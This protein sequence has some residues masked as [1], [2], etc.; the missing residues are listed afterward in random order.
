MATDILVAE[1]SPDTIERM[2]RT[3]MC[4]IRQREQEKVQ[5]RSISNAFKLYLLIGITARPR[6]LADPSG[7][8]S[9]H[10]K[11]GSPNSGQHY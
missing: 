6:Q 2:K 5:Y 10:F 1:R 3:S 8:L 11:L 9:R 7:D 4:F